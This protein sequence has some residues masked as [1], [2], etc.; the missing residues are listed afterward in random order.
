MIERSLRSKDSWFV[1]GCERP[2]LEQMSPEDAA[3]KVWNASKGSLGAVRG[4][5]VD[6]FSDRIDEASIGKIVSEVPAKARNAGGF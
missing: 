5:L 2:E 3:I 4:M 1:P 6:I